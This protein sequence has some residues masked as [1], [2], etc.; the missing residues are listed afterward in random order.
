[1]RKNNNTFQLIILYYLSF[2]YL[3]RICITAY[4]KIS[5]LLH[6]SLQP[7]Y[8][9]DCRYN[10]NV[11]GTKINAMRLVLVMR[12]LSQSSHAKL[13][14]FKVYNILYWKC[15]L[16][17]VRDQIAH[18]SALANKLDHC[19]NSI[20]KWIRSVLF[21]PQMGPSKFPTKKKWLHVDPNV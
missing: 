12:K 20:S 11:R 6:R 16:Q 8:R 4:R 1:M 3:F 7:F 9:N 21:W 13:S 2:N 14:Q 18:L 10:I 5:L 17:Q 15:W 19:T